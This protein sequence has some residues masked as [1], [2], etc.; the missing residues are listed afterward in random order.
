MNKELLVKAIRD[1]MFLE[2]SEQKIKFSDTYFSVEIGISKATL[3]RVL[4]FKE[5]DLNTI[6]SI[7]KW[8]EQPIDNFIN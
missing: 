3:S 1:K 2:M 6:I 8:L 7:C 5:V 4:N